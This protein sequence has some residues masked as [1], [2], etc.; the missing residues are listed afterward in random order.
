M[1]NFTLLQES[2]PVDKAATGAVQNILSI[3]QKNLGKQPT[4]SQCQRS[5]QGPGPSM[6]HEMRRCDI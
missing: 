6:D 4:D 2:T 3:L 1:A 5:G